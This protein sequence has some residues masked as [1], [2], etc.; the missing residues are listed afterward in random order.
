MAFVDTS[1]FGSIVIKSI[2]QEFTQY[3]NPSA[4]D[5]NLSRST[6]VQFFGQQSGGVTGQLGLIQAAH[7]G[8]GTDNNGILKAFANTGATVSIDPTSAVAIWEGTN[9]SFAVNKAST[10]A[11]N[12]T[13]TGTSTLQGVAA[14][15]L[16]VTGTSTLKGV[17]TIENNLNVTGSVQVSGN[18]SVSGT[19][20]ITNLNV[21]GTLGANVL[22]VTG[23]TTLNGAATINNNLTV[24]GTSTLKGV[25]TI[26]NNLNVTGSVQVSGNLSVSGTLLITNLNVPGTLGANVLNVTGATNLNGA[27]T[28][29][30][31]L[32][33][34]GTSSLNG[35]TTIANN[36]TVTGTSALNGATTIANTLSVTGASTFTNVL[37]VTGASGAYQLASSVFVD[38]V[39]SA[40]IGPIS[41]GVNLYV[42]RA[43]GLNG[44]LYFGPPAAVGTWRFVRSGTSL[45]TQRFEGGIFVTKNIF[46]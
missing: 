2:Q 20:L 37:N 18:L 7:S 10:I 31:N 5:A 42:D 28:I 32:T 39:G 33:V 19:L 9:S 1:N 24:T 3:Y 38:G 4:S 35:A 23:A 43:N 16:A 8:T 46:S 14:Q 30:N 22:N 34:T 6:T 45:F 17:T 44:A 40:A 41:P 21:P 27:T 15:S 29:A 26:E 11:N 12:L 36:L 25:T 13:V